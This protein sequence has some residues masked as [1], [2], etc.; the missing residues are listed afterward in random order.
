MS[1][2]SSP[3]R[4]NTVALFL[5]A[6]GAL[7]WLGGTNVRAIIAFDLFETG[8]LTYK[9]WIPPDAERQTF[10]LVAL[11]APYT[12]VGYLLTLV[13]A[14]MFLRTTHLK[15]KENGWLMMSAIM[16]YMFLPVEIYQIWYDIHLVL[17]EEAIAGVLNWF[18]VRTEA[19][20]LLKG[21]L[22]ALSGV[23]AIALMCYYT[24]IVIVVW[25]PFRVKK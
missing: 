13:G 21:R 5:L 9:T 12:I 14:T 17:Q 25:K 24:I 4:A 11:T 7:L 6:I 19:Q 8:T 1:D 10:R 22:A 18:A 2:R 15:L 3:S 20:S 23:P 16:F